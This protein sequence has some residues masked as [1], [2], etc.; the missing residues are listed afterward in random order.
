M[1]EQIYVSSDDDDE[2]SSEDDSGSEQGESNREN[3][4]KESTSNQWME[5]DNIHLKQEDKQI[6]M[7]EDMWLNDNIINAAQRLLKYQFNYIGGFQDTL[8][9]SKL[10]FSIEN[11]EFIQILNKNN[12]HWILVTNVGTEQFSYVRIVDSLGSKH[13]PLEIQNIIASMLHTPSPEIKLKFDDVQQQNDLNSCGLFA[14]AFATSLCFGKSVSTS[15]FEKKQNAIS[16]N[17]V[18]VSQKDVTISYCRDKKTKTWKAFIFSSSL[19][20]QNAIESR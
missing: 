14:V 18:P 16:F 8:L 20:L 5:V 19:Q 9:Q 17:A 1:Q 7:S 2:N 15:N 4:G 13:L 10:Q 11:G 12:N 6:L 3:H